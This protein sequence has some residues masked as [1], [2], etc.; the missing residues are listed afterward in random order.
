[1][2]S[3]PEFV[4]EFTFSDVCCF[5]ATPIAVD[6]HATWVDA[7]GGDGCDNPTGA[8]A[9]AREQAITFDEPEFYPTETLV[10]IVETPDGQVRTVMSEGDR[11]IEK[12]TGPT[13]ATDI[14]DY[15]EFRTEFPNGVLP[16]DGGRYEWLSNGW[17]QVYQD[18][19][20]LSED[21]TYSLREALDQAATA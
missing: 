6:P 9:V 12:S 7:T 11:R 10:A 20:A 1:M 19:Q 15:T 8:H 16:E 2:D 13:S 14:S 17:F 18:G 3:T 5:C 4:T 21:V